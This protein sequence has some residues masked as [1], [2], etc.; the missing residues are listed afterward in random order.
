[1]KKLLFLSTVLALASG[2]QAI[3]PTSYFYVPEKGNAL[4]RGDASWVRGQDTTET[5]TK[6]SIDGMYALT[7]GLAL[8]AA[9]YDE[10][11]TDI[12]EI[13]L[14]FVPCLANNFKA[15]FDVGYGFGSYGSDSQAHDYISAR[16]TGGYEWN[17]FVFGVFADYKHIFRFDKNNT[18]QLDRENLVGAG[19]VTN[20]TLNEKSTIDFEYRH[21]FFGR[22]RFT[23][24][25]AYKLRNYE[26]AVQLSTTY[27][28]KDNA[29][30]TPY[31]GYNWVE[32][33]LS[34][35][36]NADRNVKTF[37]VKLAVEF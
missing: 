25:S 1:M 34:K 17:D 21:S 33:G 8:T 31:I 20:Y 2:A 12:P 13:G 24:G 16:A 28:F 11:D 10:Q 4:L 19:F 15:A 5:D 27:E 26:D 7:H 3:N 18:A 30:V 36:L 23:D 9:V 29:Y 35:T 37:G 22:A 14:R 32:K 6:L